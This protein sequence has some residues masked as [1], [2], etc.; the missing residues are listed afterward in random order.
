M[1]EFSFEYLKGILHTYSNLNM[2]NSTLS[3]NFEIVEDKIEN[4]IL[5]LRQYFNLPI[6]C[7]MSIL[8]INESEFKK[9]IYDWFFL[10]GELSKINLN[11]TRRNYEVNNFYNV[12]NSINEITKIIQVEFDSTNETYYEL[13]IYYTYFFIHNKESKYLLYFRY[14]D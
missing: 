3:Y 12:L 14:D 11:E 9:Q 1:S 6:E 4:E 7:K 13:G 8:D 2:P 10:N 5:Y